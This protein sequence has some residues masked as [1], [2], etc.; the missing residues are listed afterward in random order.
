MHL[1]SILY[2]ASFSLVEINQGRM[3]WK[4]NGFDFF[5]KFHVHCVCANLFKC[6]FWLQ[7]K[8]VITK[9]TVIHV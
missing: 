5:F 4:L 3:N 1:V 9:H 7:M 2:F 8:N 6:A